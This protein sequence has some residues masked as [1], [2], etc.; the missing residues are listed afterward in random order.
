MAEHPQ[1]FQSR[2]RNG[3]VIATIWILGVVA[4]LEIVLAGIA[5]APRILTALRGNSLTLS[6]PAAPSSIST[7]TSAPTPVQATPA[8]APSAPETSDSAPPPTSTADVSTQPPAADASSQEGNTLT[9]VSAKLEGADGGPRKLTIAMKAPPK[10]KVDS[11]QISVQVFFYDDDN[12]EIAPSKAQSV[13]RWLSSGTDW[14][15][16]EPELLEV[17][18]LPDTTDPDVK[19]AG[20]VVAIYYKGDLQDYRSEPSSLT[21]LFPLKYF[22]GT[23]D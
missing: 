15:N 16:G 4:L 18:Y 19:F 23:E 12:G 9:I 3:A 10:E 17:R 2:H 20:Y 13:S 6:I 1:S 14:K 21:K 11:N 5:Q 8:A 7:S 22:I